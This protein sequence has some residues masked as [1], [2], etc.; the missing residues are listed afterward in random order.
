MNKFKQFHKIE[1]WFCFQ[2]NE[3]V[4][5]STPVHSKW[6]A[7]RGGSSER[8]SDATLGD[9][10]VFLRRVALSQSIR[11][12]MSTERWTKLLLLIAGHH[13]ES[14]RQPHYTQS[15][16]S[17]LPKHTLFKVVYFI[18]AKF[19]NHT[20]FILFS[21]K[22]FINTLLYYKIVKKRSKVPNLYFFP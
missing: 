13:K 8:V 22:Y 16:F 2:G 11:I 15:V 6:S 21:V 3:E 20:L 17:V 9:F 5:S 12:K 14:G 10:L 7:C 19:K 18:L 1:H 4:E